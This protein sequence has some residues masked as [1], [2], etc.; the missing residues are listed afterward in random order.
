MSD[1]APELTIVSNRDEAQLQRD[2]CSW[3]LSF[4]MRQLSANI[5]RVICQAGRPWDLF[6]Q[7][8]AV[9]EALANAPPGFTVG[10][11]NEALSAALTGVI[12]DRDSDTG[13]AIELIKKGALRTVAAKL[14]H[15]D[16]QAHRRNADL[17]DGIWELERIEERARERRCKEWAT[18]QPAPKARRKRARAAKKLIAAKPPPAEP[19]SIVEE[20]PKSTVEFMRERRRDLLER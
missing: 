1:E 12:D 3:E 9:R 20:E 8:L 11:A 6:D 10:D 13:Y 19:V 18:A 14:L 5:L 7:I 15:Q 2:H 4:A 17:W 16:A